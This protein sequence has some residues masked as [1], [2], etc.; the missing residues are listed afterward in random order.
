MR[1]TLM[2]ASVALMALSSTAFAQSTVIVEEP[3]VVDPGVTNSTVVEVPGEVRTYVL[4]QST[5]SVVYDGDVVVGTALPDTVELHVVQGYDGYAYTV[6]N[7]R[8]VIVDPQT[9]SVIQVLN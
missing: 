2:L 1:K 3:V 4:D 5:P 7:E 8:R 6:V 9:R